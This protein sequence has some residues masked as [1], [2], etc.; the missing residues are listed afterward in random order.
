MSVPTSI[1]KSLLLYAAFKVATWLKFNLFIA[2]SSLVI[3]LMKAQVSWMTAR[4]MHAI[5]V[6]DADRGTKNEIYDWHIH[7]QPVLH[8]R[9]SGEGDDGANG[10][11]CDFQQNQLVDM[12]SSPINEE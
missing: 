2:V 10:T 6:G 12:H 4:S 1:A 11:F 7:A 5:C 9:L 8:G 3:V